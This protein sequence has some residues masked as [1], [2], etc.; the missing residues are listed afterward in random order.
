MTNN[1]GKKESLDWHGKQG[2]SGDASSYPF[3]D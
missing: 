1:L 3:Y 2:D